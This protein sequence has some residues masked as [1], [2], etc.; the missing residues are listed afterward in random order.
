MRGAVSVPLPLWP[1]FGFGQMVEVLPSVVRWYGRRGKVVEV[2]GPET[3]R[4]YRVE[5][6]G[7]AIRP[8]LHPAELR[9]V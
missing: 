4:R 9:A 1:V 3:D 8:L 7:E 2:R 5:F 6:P